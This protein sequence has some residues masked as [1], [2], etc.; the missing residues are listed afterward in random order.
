MR[1]RMPDPNGV[2]ELRLQAAVLRALRMTQSGLRESRDIKQKRQVRVEA[3]RTA[4]NEL[5]AKSSFS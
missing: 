1:G 5:T 2:Q 4:S 3:L